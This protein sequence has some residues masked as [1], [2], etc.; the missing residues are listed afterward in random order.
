M[1]DLTH[2]LSSRAIPT[3]RCYELGT[4]SEFH[5][6][7]TSARESGQLELQAVNFPAASCGESFLQVA[8][9]TAVSKEMLQVAA[10]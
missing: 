4:C 10:V 2:E 9:A 3:T 8:D 7:D 6:F 5:H 1:T